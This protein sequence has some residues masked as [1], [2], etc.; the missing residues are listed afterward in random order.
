MLVIYLGALYFVAGLLFMLAQ[1][2]W[3]GR[4]S[5]PRRISSEMPGNTLEPANPTAGLGLKRIWPGLV[6]VLLGGGLLLVGGFL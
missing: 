3:R 1:P 4:L 5:V 6:L 2:L